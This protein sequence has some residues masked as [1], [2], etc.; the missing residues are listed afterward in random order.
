MLTEELRLYIISYNAYTEILP[1]RLIN[2][3]ARKNLGKSQEDWV[4]FEKKM[5]YNTNR[6]TYS[7]AF[8]ALQ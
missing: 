2:E 5:F 4:F 8:C 3:C 7:V 1:N 6:S